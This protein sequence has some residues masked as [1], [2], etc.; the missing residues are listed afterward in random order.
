MHVC[1]QTYAARAIV[2]MEEFEN[3][4]LHPGSTQLSEVGPAPV[5]PLRTPPG[6]QCTAAVLSC[7]HSSVLT[8]LHFQRNQQLNFVWFLVEK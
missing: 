8:S 5:Q 6:V 7:A 2:V 1:A 4:S 3:H